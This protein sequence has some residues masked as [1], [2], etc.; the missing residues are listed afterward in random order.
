MGIAVPR[1]ETPEPCSSV[2]SAALCS[3]ASAPFCFPRPL[4]APLPCFLSPKRVVRRPGDTCS[5][6]Q[7]SQ[8]CGTWAEILVGRGVTLLALGGSCSTL[9]SHCEVN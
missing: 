3:A 9:L 8:G 4:P 5:T 7:T 2:P 1:A 6:G